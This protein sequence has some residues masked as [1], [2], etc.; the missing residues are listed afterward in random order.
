LQAM[1]YFSITAKVL[2]HDKLVVN[3]TCGVLY[4][5]QYVL[6]VLYLTGFF[7]S[8]YLQHPII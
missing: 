7:H 5:N 8:M 1:Q 3:A 4:A 6:D 2:L